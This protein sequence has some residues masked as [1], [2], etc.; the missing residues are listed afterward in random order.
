MSN[1]EIDV[2]KKNE[3]ELVEAKKNLSNAKTQKDIEKYQSQIEFLTSNIKTRRRHSMFTSKNAII[4]YI[5]TTISSFLFL[6]LIL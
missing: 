4:L 6:G 2:I 1:K 3:K 5:V